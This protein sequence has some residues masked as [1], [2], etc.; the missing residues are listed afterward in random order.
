VAEASVRCEPVESSQVQIVLF[1]FPSEC[2]DV[3]RGPVIVE[4][5]R[6]QGGVEFFPFRDECC[7]SVGRFLP[8]DSLVS[9]AW[10]VCASVQRLFQSKHCLRHSAPPWM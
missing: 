5:R 2:V 3:D 10:P 6:D 7:F 1:D 9:W 8:G 4:Q